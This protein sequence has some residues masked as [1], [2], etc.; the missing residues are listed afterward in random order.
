[1]NIVELKKNI[2]DATGKI[3]KTIEDEDHN[4]RLELVDLHACVGHEQSAVSIQYEPGAKHITIWTGNELLIDAI[5]LDQIK[6]RLKLTTT[7][8]EF[9]HSI[10]DHYP[11]ARAIIT[12]THARAIVEA[13]LA[14]GEKDPAFTGSSDG[15]SFWIGDGFLVEYKE[16]LDTYLLWHE[17]EYWAAATATGL[18]E[19]Y[20][21]AL[22]FVKQLQEAIG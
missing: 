2:I 17:G 15:I 11:E 6:R 20:S 18:I 9:A 13:C 14:F 7:Y 4:W 10:L 12:P 1:M 3:W 22:V 5:E 8:T 16:D 21:D 19:T